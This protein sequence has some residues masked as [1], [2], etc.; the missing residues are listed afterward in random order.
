MPGF[1]TLGCV[2]IGP[3]GESPPADRSDY[4]EW[5]MRPVRERELLTAVAALTNRGP[6][7]EPHDGERDPA[8]AELSDP[9]ACC[10]SRTTA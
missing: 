10:W 1:A 5:L 6:G 7:S 9:L 8:R 2:L 3:A 4:V